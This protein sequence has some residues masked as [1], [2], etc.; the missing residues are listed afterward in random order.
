[1]RKAFLFTFAVAFSTIA[2]VSYFRLVE[3]AYPRT[4]IGKTDI[5]YKTRKE[6][7]SW[8]AGAY[9]NQF[10]LK[11]G[12]RVYATELRHMGVLLDRNA[13]LGTVFENNRKP[14]PANVTAFLRNARSQ[15]MLMP[16][17]V[18]TSDFSRR[19]GEARYDFTAK[20]DEISVD[21]TTK[22]LLL[23]DNEEVYRIDTE[24]L[25]S[26]VLF[27]FGKRNTTL[28]PRLIRVVKEDKQ[29]SIE[30]E[31]RKIAS[32]FSQP[33]EIVLQEGGTVSRAL[34]TPEELKTVYDV[35]YDGAGVKFTADEQA[36]GFLLDAKV[37]PIVARNRQVDMKALKTSII[38][39]F[40]ART[41]GL[42][43]GPV[44]A[45]VMKTEPTRTHGEIAQRYIEVNIA[46]Q[47][48]YLFNGGQ[49]VKSYPVSTGLYYPTPVGRFKI[50]NKALEGYS[51][52][53]SVYMPYWM[54]F[55]YGWAGGQDAYF[56]IHELPYWYVGQE[57]KQRP[58]EFL[59]S[60]HTGGC[61][62]LDIGAAKEVYEFS[63]VGMDVLIFN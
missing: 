25:K 39:S 47:K 62:S 21:R 57:R 48:M 63:Y 4:Y 32:V 31:N 54:A 18:F 51:D 27:N 23:T 59:G 37:D 45:Q 6:I 29:K 30:K 61:V 43:G 11:V 15:H 5:T 42:S 53:F 52:I 44:V 36:L 10:Y 3:R 46:A 12:S 55:H 35:S 60:P 34:L 14:F 40:H 38:A 33:L 20:E 56:G 19:I 16:V 2:I 7:D 58:R 49:M 9:R 8:L 41:G 13:T 26:L 24:H 22:T 28:E 17:L 1:M 50:M